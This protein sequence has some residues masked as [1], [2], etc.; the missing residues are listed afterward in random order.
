MTTPPLLD[1]PGYPN[2]PCIAS[3][4]MTLVRTV[5]ITASPFTKEEQA[6]KWPG[7]IWMADFKLPSLTSRAA[8]APWLAF[9]ARL[10][11]KW[12]RFLMGDPAAR[13]PRGQPT[14]T[15][16]VDGASN[17]G[18]TLETRGWSA[19]AQGVLLEGDYI[20]IGT[21]VSSRLKMVTQD[22]NADSS[23]EA[24]ISIAPDLGSSPADG[25]AIITTN[26]RGIFRL[27]ENSFSWSVDPGPVYR[28]SFSAVE[29]PNA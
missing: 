15:P 9:G 20:Q 25:T 6:F 28:I 29:V 2:A 4:T 24:T 27:T 21:G 18:N 19:N 13:L 11:G 23:G 22:V 3:V 12:G 16:V 5:G 10:E 14:G 26:A 7:E 17:T 1:L 8:A